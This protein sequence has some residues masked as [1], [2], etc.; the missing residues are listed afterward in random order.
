MS[1]CAIFLSAIL[2]F[3]LVT[4]EFPGQGSA[5]G[6]GNVSSELSRHLCWADTRNSDDDSEGGSEPEAPPI[7]DPSKR[8]PARP[9]DSPPSKSPVTTGPPKGG[10]PATAPQP[11]VPPS[12]GI[13]VT[14][15]EGKLG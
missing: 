7:G 11:T 1:K 14:S 2:G 13:P 12:E 8:P 9:K 3:V 5:F 10:V 15:G 6:E 4:V